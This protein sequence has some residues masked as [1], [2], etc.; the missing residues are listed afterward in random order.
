MDS[1]GDGAFGRPVV[2]RSALKIA[3]QQFTR[4]RA[5][6]IGE[7]KIEMTHVD[8]CVG[9]EIA[10]IVAGNSRADRQVDRP[11]IGALS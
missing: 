9:F 11:A 10:A 5:R 6:P 8:I 2:E 7:S 1:D 3:V 4:Y